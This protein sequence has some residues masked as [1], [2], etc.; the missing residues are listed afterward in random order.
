M[1]L[2]FRMQSHARFISSTA[3]PSCC[4]ALLSLF[5]PHNPPTRP[6]RLHHKDLITGPLSLQTLSSK[7]SGCLRPWARPGCGGK[8]WGVDDG[9]PEGRTEG[10]K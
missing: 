8:C 9:W 6:L 7:G 5:C 10:R 1:H 4:S 2:G 3:P